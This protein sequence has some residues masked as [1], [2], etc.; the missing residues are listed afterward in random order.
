[1]FARSQQFKHP[2]GVFSADRLPEDRPVNRDNCIGR[3]YHRGWV[4]KPSRLGLGACKT[5]R[6]DLRVPMR[7]YPFV[8]VNRPYHER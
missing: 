7:R 8:H 3:D 2:L 5:P 4:D 6:D 1:M